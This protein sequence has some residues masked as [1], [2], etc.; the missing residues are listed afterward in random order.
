MATLRDIRSRANW[1]FHYGVGFGRPPV[2]RYIYWMKGE[3]MGI[4]GTGNRKQECRKI[5]AQQGEEES[6][7]FCRATRSG[8]SG[9]Q[10]VTAE[11]KVFLRCGEDV[12]VWMQPIRKF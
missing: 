11:W 10:A 9:E 7:M 6:G 12:E 3:N 1:F 4:T 2:W 8:C 5:S